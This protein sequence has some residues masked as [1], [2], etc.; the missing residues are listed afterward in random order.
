MD[1]LKLFS[2]NSNMCVTFRL[3]SVTFCHTSRDA[4][5]LWYNGEIFVKTWTFWVLYHETV[6]L[7]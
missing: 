2:D 4:S 7:I 5:G 1:A 3:T 6:G